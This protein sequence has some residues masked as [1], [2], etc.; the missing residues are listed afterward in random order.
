MKRVGKVSKEPPPK[1]LVDTNPNL[2]GVHH[3]VPYLNAQ[4]YLDIWATYS[5]VGRQSLVHAK[6]R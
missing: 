6:G 4:P 5:V 1:W 3:R 2:N